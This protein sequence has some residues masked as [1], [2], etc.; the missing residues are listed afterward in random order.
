MTNNFLK[1][2]DYAIT[3]V[4]DSLKRLGVKDDLIRCVLYEGSKEFKKRIERVH[5]SA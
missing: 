3:P 2:Y 1:E 4:Y 5:R